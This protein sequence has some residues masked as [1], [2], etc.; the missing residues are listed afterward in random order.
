MA[1]AAQQLLLRQLSRRP[2]GI[3]GKRMLRGGRNS[4]APNLW[5]CDFSY[6]FS[7]RK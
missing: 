2:D 4:P 3:A 6:F 7:E 1:H 5:F